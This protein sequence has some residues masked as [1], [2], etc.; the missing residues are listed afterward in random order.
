MGDASQA[1][2]ERLQRDLRAAMK[3]RDLLARDLLRALI[4][5]ID[6]AGA[7]AWEETQAPSITTTQGR[8]R[9]VV[10]GAGQTEVARKPLSNEAIAALFKREAGERCAAADAA[11]R[12]G[13]TEAAK[14]LRDRADLVEVYLSDWFERLAGS[15]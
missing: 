3:A 12:H 4:A 5:A 7:V 2:R 1:I 13:K 9:Y 8:S 10:T 15:G 14:T 11:E 6:N